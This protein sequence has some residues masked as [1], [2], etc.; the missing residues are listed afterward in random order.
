MAW[1]IFKE[2][3]IMTLKRGDITRISR[4]V[5]CSTSHFCDILHGRSRPSPDLSQKLEQ[6]TGVPAVAW[7]WPA[8]YNNPLLKNHL[9][10]GAGKE[11]VH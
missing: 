2:V 8:K 11:N 6:V 3:I 10:K 7:L 1:T 9:Q 4:E 5:G